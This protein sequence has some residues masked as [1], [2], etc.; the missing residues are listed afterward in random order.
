VKNYLKTALVALALVTLT[1]CG[2]G[3]GGDSA[4]APVAPP[5][6]GGTTSVT[7]TATAL[8]ASGPALTSTV[9]QAAANALVP[10]ACP[11]LPATAYAATTVVA[12]SGTLTLNVTILPAGFVNGVLTATGLASGGTWDVVATATGITVTPRAGTATDWATTYSGTLG[13]C[14]TNAPC[15]TKNITFTTGVNPAPTC[16]APAMLTSA[17]TCISPPA[18]TGYTWNNIMKAWIADI[19]VLVTGA[20]TL[21]AACVTIGDA[22]WLESVAN[23]TVKFVNSGAVRT[24][25]DTRPIS[26]AFYITKIGGVDYYNVMPMYADVLATAV[27][28]NQS[29]GNGSMGNIISDVKG[30]A[31]GANQTVPA[32]GCYERIWLGGGFGNTQSTCPI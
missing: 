32:F 31:L 18:A 8:C 15:V 10:N 23:G 24:G 3:G 27:A 22:C 14:F 11:A 2:G 20:N 21:P 6:V 4:P 30:T 12:G 17:K 16:T 5:P 29:V 9:S 28:G 1:A 25:F 13:M 7:Y 26:F 19:G